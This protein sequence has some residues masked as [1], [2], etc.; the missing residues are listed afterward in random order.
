MPPSENALLLLN[1]VER[2]LRTLEFGLDKRFPTEDWGFTAQQAMEK[3][4]KGWIVLADEEPPRSHEL[5]ELTILESIQELV[6]AFQ[7][8]ID[9]S[10]EIR[11][12]AVSKRCVNVVMPNGSRS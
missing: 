6:V 12:L 1:S 3:V 8:A 4:L 10:E 5:S 9:A 2:H 11:Q 7:A